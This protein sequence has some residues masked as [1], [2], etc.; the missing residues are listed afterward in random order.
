MAEKL[1]VP[2][3][4]AGN[5]V[6]GIPSTGIAKVDIIDVD[7]VIRTKDGGMII[8]PGAGLGSMADT[9]PMVAFSDKEIPADLLMQ[10]LGTE[11][12]VADDIGALTS[13]DSSTPTAASDKVATKEEIKEAVEQAVKEAK[14]EFEKE[15][16]EEKQHDQDNPQVSALTVNTEASVEAT[17]EKAQKIIENLNTSNYDYTPP[18]EFTPPP[19]AS[20]SPP[21]VPAPISLTPVVTLFM[22]NV[23]GTTYDTTTMPGTTIIYGGGGAVGSEAASQIGPRN[24]QQFSTASIVGTSG[25]DLIYAQGPAVGNT[26]PATSTTMYAKEF[27]LN[28]AGYFITMNDIVFSGVP[29]GVSIVGA[30]DNGDGTWTLPSE[31]VTNNDSFTMIYDTTATG[32]FDITVTVTG[33]TTRGS[34]F[35]SEQSFRFQ[36][37]AV[38]DV[39]QVNDPSLVYE[40]GGRLREIYVL[41]TMDQPNLITAGEGDDS[42]YGGRSHDTITGGN[43]NNVVVAKEGDDDVTLGNG[44][45][46]I[47]LGDGENIA[48]TG[49]GNDTIVATDGDNTIDAGSGANSL[50]MGNGNNTLSTGAGNDTVVA[51]D[52]ENELNDSAGNNT[53]TMGDGENTI[54]L[55][56]GDNSITVG[57]GGNR[58]TVGLG[59]NAINSGTG[60]D[61]ITAGDGTNTIVD[62]GGD[63]I[64]ATGAG[65]DSITVGDGDNTILGGEGDN[66]IIGGVGETTLTTGAGNDTITLASGG[67]SITAGDGVNVINVGAGDYTI[68]SGAGADT[69]VAGVGNH[70]ISAG[71]GN[72]SVTL[73]DGIN[74][75]TTGSGND[76]LVGGAGAD[77]FSAGLGTNNITGGGGTDTV[78]YSA[79][80]TT[81][82]TLS[83]A[84]GTA[85]GT[86]LSDTLTNIAYVIGTGL[87]D[88]ITGS[89]GDNSILGGDGN[90]SITG[91]GGNDT[92]SGDLGNDVLV[93]GS[94]LDVIYGG[95]GA[96]SL[97]GGSAGADSL[98]G[99]SGSDTFLT[100]HEGMVFYG[101]NG[102]VALADGEINTINYSNDTAGM[103]INLQ[104]GYGTGGLADGSIYISTNVTGYNSIN[105]I[106]GG[107]GSDSITG[108]SANDYI[109]GGTGARDTL[110]GGLGNNTLEGG[111]G[112]RDE[113]RMGRGNDTIIGGT[114]YDVVYYHGSGAGVVVNL[115]STTQSFVN[116]LGVTMTVA[117]YSGGNFGVTTADASSYSVGDYYTPISGTSTSISELQGSSYADLIF[118]GSDSLLYYNTYG[119]VDTMYGGVGNDQYY[120]YEQKDY[121]YG[122]GGN[123]TFY[124]SNGA[125]RAD[126]GT[127]FNTLRTNSY[128]NS[129]NF[130]VVIYLDATA[131]TNSNGIADY[132]D[133]G[134]T[135]LTDSGN[136]VTYTGFEYGWGNTTS[137]A[138]AM[139]VSNFDNIIG[140][141]GNDYFVGNA[142]ANQINATGGS[143]TIYGLGGNDIITAIDGTNVIDGG[144]GTDL[145][146]FQYNNNAVSGSIAT[147]GSSN[148]YGVQVFLADGSFV[149]ASDKDSYWGSSFS[150]YQSRTGTIG[151]YF[152]STITGVENINGSDYTDVLYGNSSANVIYGNS[153]ADIIAGNGGADSLYGGNDNDTFKVTSSDLASVAVFDGGSGSDTLYASGATFTTGTVTNSKYVSIETVDARN[154]VAGGAYSLSATDVQAF[155]DNGNSSTVLLNLDSGDTFNA[156]GFF[157][158]T[159]S[160]SDFTYRYY[161]DAGLTTQIAVLNV[162]YGP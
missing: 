117:A 2:A 89:T 81:G 23:V 67:G 137:G 64:I 45:N 19:G 3:N 128:Y 51:G 17:V 124:F 112:S 153:G 65:N 139:L 59:V 73:G 27:N 21:G 154:S 122:G 53:I 156:S 57:D 104:A 30:T 79:V 157:T 125:D 120:G 26:D 160:G 161:S 126:G 110:I 95:A 80:T 15:Q 25:N 74:S 83:L 94:G 102:T 116:S 48:V 135:T 62:T 71:D 77:T 149:G 118:A 75:I 6:T 129:S 61:I 78:D 146:N 41:P 85:T 50:T 96:D 16:Q 42:I 109:N 92:L 55:S 107:S 111:G 13:A 108:S 93:G 142:N 115:S 49:T 159:G 38:T 46:N 84:A 114:S 12:R 145:V 24:S 40:D 5:Y 148:T 18:H 105:G 123:D 119:G 103:T 152:Y 97:Y 22:G 140:I 158:T 11:L 106:I 138:N 127:G 35:L 100:P 44:N 9:P 29:T 68:T 58:I 56:D 63:N 134:V 150:L 86:G 143:N 28:V 37:M 20:A 131:D 70:T 1:V 60:D 66:S 101:T 99:G 36:Y 10:G 90:D 130:N 155:A 121:F 162:H 72:N 98:Y 7:I 52:G 76:T 34:E 69:I 54:S 144:T 47:D 88:T 141:N 87:A 8:L 4:G 113:Y 82:I 43:G 91:N 39:S 31:Y 147:A 32:T 14:A 151:A 132:I 33:D 136:G 133:R